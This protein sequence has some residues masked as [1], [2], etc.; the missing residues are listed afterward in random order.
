M[1][2]NGKRKG[3]L[4]SERRLKRELQTVLEIEEKKDAR[5]GL[6]VHRKTS[7]DMSKVLLSA[8]VAPSYKAVRSIV[9]LLYDV[10]EAM[11]CSEERWLANGEEKE[12][13]TRA[14]TN[15]HGVRLCQTSAIEA[16]A[17]PPRAPSFPSIP[18]DF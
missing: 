2:G 11:K 5:Y 15:R 6:E 14:Y 1:D 18:S 7:E 9:A 3:E 16:E 17:P 8:G 13:E 10:A 4:A 12:Y